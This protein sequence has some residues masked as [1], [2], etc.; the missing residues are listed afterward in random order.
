MTESP[1]PA[2]TEAPEPTSEPTEKPEPTET[3]SPTDD[4]ALPSS[5]DDS[6]SSGMNVLYIVL[7]IIG[8][9]AGAALYYV[10]I[11]ISIKKRGA[12]TP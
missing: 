6:D 1:K 12:T 11:L 7:P 5:E 9:I 4:T 2:P 8:A 3:P 10:I